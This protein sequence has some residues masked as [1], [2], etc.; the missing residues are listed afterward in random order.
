MSASGGT[1][2]AQFAVSTSGTLVYLTGSG[3]NNVMPIAWMDRT[4]QTTVMHSMP[5][6]WSELKRDV[7]GDVFNVTNAIQRL[8]RMKKDPWADFFTTKQT[9]TR[10]MMTRVRPVSR[11]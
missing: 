6:D 8:A 5:I 1:G 2:A 3:D 10:G 11:R 9:I 7:R 4:G